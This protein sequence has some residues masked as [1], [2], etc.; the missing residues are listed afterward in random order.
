MIL[1]EVLMKYFAHILPLAIGLLVAGCNPPQEVEP[2]SEP[3]LLRETYHS[4]MEDAERDYFVY[5]PPDFEKQDKWP[6]ILFLH[7]NGE[8]GD[9]KGDLD[10]L[11]RNGPL[12]EA[13]CQRRDLPFVIISPQMPMQ[14]QGEIHYL[15][16]R[17]RSELPE[18]KADGSINVRPFY[19]RSKQPFDGQLSEPIPAEWGDISNKPTGWNALD[20][21]VMSMLDHVLTTYR[22]DPKRVY[23]TGLSTGGAGTWVMGAAHPERFAAIAPMVGIG[24]PSLAPALVNMPIWSFAGGRDTGAQVKYFYP[25]L[26]K[27]EELGHPDVKFTIEAD[28]GHDAFI[29][30]YASEDLYT[31]F[32]EH[33]K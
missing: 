15:K 22:G 10:Y 16:N 2:K 30:A 25:L 23:L 9:G 3:Q 6:V 11:L 7:G 4:A 13:W 32:L 12:F 26:N 1:F 31:W 29:R 18:R 5:L 21:E 28:L 14:D 20:S 17:S 33:S 19:S 24:S 8:R 27:L